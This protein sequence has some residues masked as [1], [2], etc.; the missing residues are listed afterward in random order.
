MNR[1][2]MSHFLESGKVIHVFIKSDSFY[3]SFTK[4]NPKVGGK[5]IIHLEV[6]RALLYV[7]KNAKS[8]DDWLIDLCLR[9]IG[10]IAAI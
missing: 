5:K 3:K 8:I 2:I 6:N 1:Q 10:N 7:I 9:R 4:R